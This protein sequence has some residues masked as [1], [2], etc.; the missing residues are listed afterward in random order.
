MSG[1]SLSWMKFFPKLILIETLEYTVETSLPTAGH[2]FNSAIP[3][4]LTH[5]LSRAPQ[6][7]LLITLL[8]I[9]GQRNTDKWGGGWGFRP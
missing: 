1:T 3:N 9:Q 7:L 8:L 4:I 6:V 5:N 2:S